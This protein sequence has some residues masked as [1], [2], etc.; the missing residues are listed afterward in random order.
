MLL[1]KTFLEFFA[2]EIDKPFG[3]DIMPDPP[4]LIAMR[5]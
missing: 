2:V 4:H 3:G 5:L 1:Q